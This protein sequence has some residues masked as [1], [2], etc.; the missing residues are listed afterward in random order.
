MLLKNLAELAEVDLQ[1]LITQSVLERRNLEY[2]SSLPGG[3]DAEKKEFLADVSSFANAIGGDII[4]GIACDNS[5][6]MPVKV[7]GLSVSNVDEEILRLDNSIRD[8]I[9]HRLIGVQIKK[10]SLA[11]AKTALVIHIPRSWNSPH[12][13][14]YKG[15]D[16][17]YSRSTNGK[18]PLDVDELR[19]AFGLSTTLADK[20]R[21]FR[22]DRISRILADDTPLLLS[23]GPKIV[24]H[25]IPFISLTPGRI[26]DITVVNNNPVKLKPIHGSSWGNR[27]NL[28]GVLTWSGEENGRCEAY[29]QFFRNGIVEATEASMLK[30]WTER[31]IIPSVLFEQELMRSLSAYLSLMKELSIELPAYVFL[32]LLGVRG[33]AMGTSGHWMGPAPLVDRDNLLFSEAVVQSYTDEPKDVLHP[34]FDSVWNAAGLSRSLNYGH[35]GDWTGRG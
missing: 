21:T 17:F 35:N 27:Y 11:N 33:Y 18:Y 29:V 7:E 24:L 9:E 6:G 4:F 30:P 16:K 5:T 15:H 12:R 25:V 13:V 2:K 32:A 28:D 26:Y 20:I 19:D 8:G 3:T 31:L 22:I 34:L 1:N 23:Q 10:I 14:T